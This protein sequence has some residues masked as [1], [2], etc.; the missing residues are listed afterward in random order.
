[1]SSFFETASA[2]PSAAATSSCCPRRFASG[3]DNVLS[4]KGKRDQRITSLFLA[5]VGIRARGNH[6]EL[7]PAHPIGDRLGVRARRK[8]C[9]PQLLAGRGGERVEAAIHGAAH[10]D[11]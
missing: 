1:M 6:D 3:S 4:G 7:P 8:R 5:E 9:G 10:E 2:C 11:D